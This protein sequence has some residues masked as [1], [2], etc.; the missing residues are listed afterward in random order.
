MAF[1]ASAV[2]ALAWPVMTPTASKTCST[3]KPLA[4]SRS[5]ICAGDSSPTS[6][7]IQ[8]LGEAGEG[9][10]MVGRRDGARLQSCQE[11]SKK[12]RSD[13]TQI[14]VGRTSPCG[15]PGDCNRIAGDAAI[16]HPI[17]VTGVSLN[18]LATG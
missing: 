3:A 9:V 10:G 11:N 7:T 16:A 5:A 17:D 4:R 8:R 6:V 12:E 18:F 14:P 1:K 15:L 13:S 2:L